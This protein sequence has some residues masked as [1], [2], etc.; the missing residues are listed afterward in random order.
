MEPADSFQ[1]AQDLQDTVARSRL[2]LEPLDQCTGMTAVGPDFAPAA[3]PLEQRT[4]SVAIRH[5]GG[6]DDDP[7]Q[8][9]QRVHHYM[10]FAAFDLFCRHRSHW[11]RPDLRS[12]WFDCPRWRHWAGRSCP[13][14][15]ALFG[16]ACDGLVP[17]LPAAASGGNN[18]APWT[19]GQIPW[20]ADAR[21]S[22]SAGE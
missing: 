15:R 22:R 12:C 21:R 10:A 5:A 1:M 8:Q 13:P 16:A 19:T 14:P 3:E 7:Q 9:A 4:C 20:A 2:L 6:S 11:R 17:T 18:H